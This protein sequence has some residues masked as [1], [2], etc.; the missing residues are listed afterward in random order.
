MTTRRKTEAFQV[1]SDAAAKKPATPRKGPRAKPKSGP[2]EVTVVP[3]QVMAAAKELAKGRDV[4]LA[5][6]RDGSM[7][8]LNGRRM[9]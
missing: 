3:K 4:H 7:Y 5:V 8:V 9:T 1:H 2:V 6:G